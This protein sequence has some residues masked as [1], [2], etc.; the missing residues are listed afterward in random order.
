[1]TVA[2]APGIVEEIRRRLDPT[3]VT[4]TREHPATARTARPRRR[5]G[6][7][8][9]PGVDRDHPG[10]VRVRRGRVSCCSRPGSSTGTAN[11]RRRTPRSTPPSRRRAVPVTDLLSTTGPPAQDVSWRVVTATG[12]FDPARQFYVRL[13]QD[14]A[15][16]PVSE[17]IVPFRLASGQT[18][19]VDRGYV[20]V[21]RRQPGRVRS[22]RCRPDRSPSP[23]G[24]SRSR[25]TRRTGP[26]P[27]RRPGG[28]LRD[29]LRLADGGRR[30]HGYLRRGPAP[31]SSCRATSS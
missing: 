20:V 10:R 24:C 31:R 28:G 29:Q 5:L 3:P 19:L 14:S 21:R 11:G 1:M 7:P 23:A 8:A 12:E 18:L 9:A 13:R 2:A 26:R 22:R 17:V 15:G 27:G 6:V 25:S 4:N 16:Q 30:R